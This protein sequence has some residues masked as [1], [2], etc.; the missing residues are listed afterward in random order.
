MC[1][2]VVCWDEQV[3]IA[4][5]QELLQHRPELLT[6]LARAAERSRSD[7]PLYAQCTPYNEQG[8]AGVC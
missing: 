6:I 1:V 7:L 4:A 2:S 8:N 5:A 3:S